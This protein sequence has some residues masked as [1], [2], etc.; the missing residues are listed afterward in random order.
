[1]RLGTVVMWTG[2]GT[3]VKSMAISLLRLVDSCS[4]A[5]SAVGAYYH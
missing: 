5:C 1:M 3:E 4:G 2:P